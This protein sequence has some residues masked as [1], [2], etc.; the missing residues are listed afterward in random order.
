ML[1]YQWDEEDTPYSDDYDLWPDWLYQ[2]YNEIPFGV[3][4]EIAYLALKLEKHR[5]I[6]KYDNICSSVSL[7]KHFL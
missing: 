6:S 5:L 4:I 3:A 2:Y 7:V 1:D